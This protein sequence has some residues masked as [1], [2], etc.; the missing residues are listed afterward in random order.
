ML[1]RTGHTRSMSS[2][3]SN[4]PQSCGERKI[5]DAVRRGDLLVGR[6]ST[7]TPR[8]SLQG[9]TWLWHSNGLITAIASLRPLNESCLSG[10]DVG[11]LLVYRALVAHNH[12]IQ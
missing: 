5:V 2:K 9:R 11:T 6:N 8:V 10:Y 3:R 7:S 12:Y 1:L 4:P